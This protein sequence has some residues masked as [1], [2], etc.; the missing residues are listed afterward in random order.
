MNTASYPFQGF[1]LLLQSVQLFIKL[2]LFIEL[3]LSITF[4]FEPG[5]FTLFGFDLFEPLHPF[6]QR[7]VVGCGDV[8]G[9]QGFDAL[10]L[11]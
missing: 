6:L 2:H 11:F 9:H 3:L 4:G 5:V 10:E 1:Y 7:F 8:W